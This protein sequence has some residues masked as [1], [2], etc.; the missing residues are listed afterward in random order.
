MGLNPDKIYR[1]EELQRKE[2][3]RSYYLIV[4]N[5][6][7][8]FYFFSL[9]EE[10]Q[11]KRERWTVALVRKPR[12]PEKLKP[13]SIKMTGGNLQIIVNMVRGH[14]RDGDYPLRSE[15]RVVDIETGESVEFIDLF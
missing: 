8:N 5:C 10:K 12:D 3:S 1:L 13:A 2:R 7:D 11:Q 6:W 4:V 14:F 9:R 15:V